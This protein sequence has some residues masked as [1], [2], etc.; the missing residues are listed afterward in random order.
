[1]SE[2]GQQLTGATLGLTTWPTHV[3]ANTAD[4]TYALIGI[5]LKSTHLD[6]IVKVKDIQVFSET[7]DNFY[8]SLLLNPSVAGT[9]S[10]SDVTNAPIQAAYG[11]TANT[12]TGGTV[13]ACGLSAAAEAATSIVD[14]LL[15]LGSKID[16]TADTIVLCA[17]PAGTNEDLQAVMNI[18][19][20]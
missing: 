8:W 13:L 20:S 15:Y 3:D 16:G 12:V 14:N 5:K 9:F 4:E 1:M 2:G 10:Y 19:Y 6:N 17:S 18:Q 11:A 7:N